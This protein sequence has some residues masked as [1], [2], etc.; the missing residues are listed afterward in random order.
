MATPLVYG[1]YF[2][3]C[4]WNGVLSCYDAEDGTRRY[5]QRLGEGASAFTASPV[6]GA[7]KIYIAGEDGEVY[8]IQAGPTFQLLAKNSLDEACLA[9][10]AIS[11]GNII[12]RTQRHLVAI[13][14]SP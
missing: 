5:Q 6:A 1:E 8:V 3:N 14:E 11:E 2:Y 9:S 12:F 10:P 7:G 4:R 13:S